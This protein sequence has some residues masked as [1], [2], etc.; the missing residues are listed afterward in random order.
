MNI[1]ITGLTSAGKSILFS[2]FTGTGGELNNVT[3]GIV[4]VPDERL[5]RL[6]ALFN[7][8]KHTNTTVKFE[9]CPAMDTPVKQDKIKLYDTLKTMDALVA[10]IG[11]YQRISPE[12]AVK[13]F[14]QYRFEL[15]MNDLDFVVKRIERLEKEILKIAKNRAE[16]EK[17]LTLMQKLQP[18]LEG[19]K[20]LQGLA[21]DD[22]EKEIL[23]NANLITMKP[24][25]YVFNISEDTDEAYKTAIAEQA[26]QIISEAGENS[27][28]F[29]INASLEAEL[30]GMEPEDM[31]EFMQ[32]YGIKESGRERVIKAVYNMLDLI[33]FFTVGEDECRG[34]TL[35][36]GSTALDAAGAI[37]SDLARGFIRAEIIEQD[38]LLELKSMSAAKKA[39]RLRLEGRNYIVKDGDI[40]HIM[41]NT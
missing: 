30:A 18:I 39:G 22:I 25:C 23:G 32:E 2:S 1:G 35:R 29:V 36:K 14:K 12:E 26:A 3:T 8:K 17:E 5:D 4:K 37:H 13:E 7:P 27:P 33:T 16:R 10:V 6:S 19:E 34:W 24:V 9:D 41:F 11:A 28:V 40:A 31:V 21:F 15:M 20:T 38:V